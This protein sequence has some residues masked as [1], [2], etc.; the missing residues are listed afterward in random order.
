MAQIAESGPQYTA[1]RYFLG[2]YKL[3]YGFIMV[4]TLISTL[5]ESI[6]VAAFFPLFSS[7]LNEQPGNGAGILGIM[8][9]MVE[10]LPISSVV[11]ASSVLLL[12]AFLL[13]TVVS[14]LRDALTAYTG[15]R[16]LYD[17]KKQ[18]MDRY[19]G[20]SY[21]HMVNSRQGTLVYNVLSA[22]NDVSALLL[23]GSRMTASIFRVFAITAVLISILPLAAL[24][25]AGLG[26]VYYLLIHI[27]SRKVT[28]YLGRGKAR[29]AAEQ[30]VTANEF[31]N[32]IRQIIA[33]NTTKRWVERFDGHSKEFSGYYAKEQIWLAVPRPTMEIFGLALMVG[34][35][36]VLR[37]SDSG[38]FVERLATIGVFAVALVQ[39]M[40]SL[41]S[42]GSLRMSIM[43]ALP[44]MDLAYQTITDPI[45]MR[46]VSTRTMGKF[47][48][49]I[50]FEKV[51]FGYKGRAEL[52]NNLNLTFKK[53]EITAIVG[54]SG[55]GKTTIVNLL[56]GMFDPTEG[57]VTVDGI[58]LSDLTE[59]S[60]LKKIGFVSQD[61][62][63]YHATFTDNIIFGRNGGAEDS[64]DRATKIANVH[65][66]ISELPEC[67]ETIIG[68]RGMTISGG[69]QQRLA[70][71]RAVLKSPEI[72]IFDEATSSLD[73]I[74]E[75]L[76]QEAIDSA[77]SN[78][79]VIIIAHRLSTVRNA[80]KIIV[81]DNGQ[82]VEEGNH[83]ELLKLGGRYSLLAA[84][85]D[86]SIN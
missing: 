31:L 25:L 48:Q 80:D 75:R 49:Q 66:F 9:R 42:I 37:A 21:E 2:R 7:L 71:A 67:Y 14:F 24:A 65:D 58:P 27:L 60:W 17:V 32:G 69:Q 40:P 57:R 77:S 5:L 51:S 35:I 76:V 1:V 4:A 83:A 47:E 36:L 20:A 16:V 28:Y 56:M 12:S 43:S 81:M 82:V 3:R 84:S 46:R 78:R 23:A 34:I 15:A 70:I 85:S 44:N 45:K 73:T 54:Q 26:L 6:S 68:D 72:L 33:F 86:S 39:L 64:V 22:P 13:K 29:T 11:V 10:I 8:D 61:L 19:A 18:I 79:T 50:S 30:N 59:E 53:G 52:F 55:S 41:T 38:V 62:F 63:I 74:S